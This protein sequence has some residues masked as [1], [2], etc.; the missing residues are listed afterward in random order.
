M[1]NVVV[2]GVPR[3]DDDVVEVLAMSSPPTAKSVGARAQRVMRSTRAATSHDAP[4]GVMRNWTYALFY[5]LAN[6]WGSV[7]VSLMQ[8]P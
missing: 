4:A 8:P 3:D 7:V 2:R 5:L 1:R 6:M